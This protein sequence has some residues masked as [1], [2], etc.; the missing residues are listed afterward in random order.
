MS[1]NGKSLAAARGKASAAETEDQLA[2][3]RRRRALLAVPAIAAGVLYLLSGILISSALSSAPTVGLLQ[4]LKPAISE[5][6][7]EQAI[8]PRTREVTFVS[9]HA[10]PLIV[11]S[12]LS[13]ISL[14]VLTAVLLLLVRATRFRRPESWAPTAVLVLIGGIGFAA[15]GI[16]HQIA[17]AILTHEFAVG[18]DHSS[19]AV[20]HAL[21]S[22]AANVVSE[23]ISLLAGLALAAGM[24]SAALGAM[25]VGLIAR[26]MG[27][28][29]V[30]SALLIFLPIGGAEL[31][32]IPAFW[33]AAMG[34]LLMR[35]WPAGDPPAWEAGEARPWPTQA[36]MRAR[37]QA[38]TSASGSAGGDLSAPAPE[39]SRTS[40]S[41]RRRRKHGS[42]R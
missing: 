4:A 22:G 10:L 39:P 41:G 27:V 3:E 33:L 24:I 28:V 18:S 17:S 23:Y 40:S 19:A 37:Q 38:A 29:G 12:A 9:H 26:W 20:E 1:S 2:W 14:I 25:R 7:A 11:G 31:E 13:S 35:R 8:S 42:H 32:I 30:I 21:T 6:V 36:E 34:I 5:G 15:V 16:G